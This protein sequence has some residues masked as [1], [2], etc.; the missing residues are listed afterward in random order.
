MHIPTALI[1]PGCYPDPTIC[2]KGDDYY[3]ANSSFGYFPGVPIHHS[4][5]LKN[6]TFIGYALNRPS[7]LPL[8]SA[9]VGIGGIYAPTLRYHDGRFWLIT[10]NLSHTKHFIVHATDPAGPWSEPIRIDDAHQGGIDPDLFWDEDGRVHLCCTRRGAAPADPHNGIYRFEVDP[11]TGQGSGGRRFVWSGTGGMCPEGPH[12]Y[13]RG[14]FHYLLI[15]EGGSGYGHMVTVAR[16]R[17]LDGPWES[18]PHNPILTHRSLDTRIQ[19]LGHADM[20]ELHD[21]QWAIVFLGVRATGA[22]HLGRESFIAPVKWNDEGWPV[23]QGEGVMPFEIPAHPVEWS[24]EFSPDADLWKIG[25]SLRNPDAA[26]YSLSERPGWL[27]L[28]GGEG[29]LDAGK[30]A[31]ELM[32]VQPWDLPGW[33]E[34]FGKQVTFWGIRQRHFTM[35]ARVTLD[36]HPTRAG[37]EAGLTVFMS[38]RCHYKISVFQENG[39]RQAAL[40]KSVLDIDVIGN[41]VPMSD[42]PLILEVIAT[43]KI[44]AFFVTDATGTR[45]A[46]GTGVTHLLS[47]DVA[48]GFTGVYLGPFAVDSQNG[49]GTPAD[50]AQLT[51]S[52]TTIL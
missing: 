46:L 49:K 9:P 26:F 19:C 44:Y 2:R 5:D 42:G 29:G 25:N 34:S 30:P 51:Y 15:A 37:E 31:P 8:A 7:Q 22:R 33:E 28:R 11:L 24:A 21:G 35:T 10:T 50:F 16:S 48:G 4:R 14:G 6:W 43:P 18:C 20:I 3:I 13:R 41:P 38:E 47:T 52:A 45:H 32:G 27:R 12:L 36:Y 17:F 1:L 40:G 23:V 39:L